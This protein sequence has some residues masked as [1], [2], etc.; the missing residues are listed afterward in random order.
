MENDALHPYYI[1]TFSQAQ[2]KQTSR[3][4]IEEQAVNEVDILEIDLGTTN[5]D[6]AIWKLDKLNG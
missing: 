3:P 4:Q 1:Y 6:I 5:S 2:G